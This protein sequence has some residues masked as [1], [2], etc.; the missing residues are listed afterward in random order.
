MAHQGGAVDVMGWYND[1]PIVSKLYLTLAIGTTTAC[2]MDVISPLTLYYSYDLILE[3]HQ[4]WRIFSSFLYFGNFSLDFLFQLFFVGRYCLL[5]EE[6]K[7]RGRTADFIFMIIFGALSMLLLAVSFERFS[8]IKFLGHPLGFMM[9][10]LWSRCP[11]NLN[12]RMAFLGVVQ[13]HAPYLPWVLLVFSILI[14]NSIETDLMGIIVGHV[15]YFLEDV[16]PKIA[17]IRGWSLKKIFVAP[18]FANYFF[19]TNNLNQHIQVSSLKL[20]LNAF[21]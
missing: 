7:Y 16:Y 9:T 15:I 3:K 21:S 11:E 20:T 18:N 8:K 10:Y 6:G 4:Y 14:G 19:G 12:A 1:L 2:F 17:N 5:L 13:F